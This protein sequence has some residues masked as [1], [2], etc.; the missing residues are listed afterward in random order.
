[1]KSKSFLCTA[2]VAGALTV[3]LAACSTTAAPPEA[4]TA[5]PIT[6]GMVTPLTGIYSALGD[7]ALAAVES[8]V[9]RINAEGGI[10]GHQVNLVYRDDKSEADQSIIAYNELASDPTVV[11][12]LSSSSV[13]NSAATGPA[14]ERAEVPTI[15]LG[16]VQQFTDGSN[17]Y[18]FTA[19]AATGLYAQ[20]I[21]NYVMATGLDSIAVVYALTPY[22][23][24][25]R[26]AT[27]G[28][29]QGA[30]VDIVFEQ[31]FDDQATDFTAVVTGVQASGADGIIVWGTGPAPVILTKQFAAAQVDAQ[32]IFTG[33]QGSSLFLQPAGDA[34]EGVIV[35]TSIAVAGQELPESTLKTAIDV[36]AVPFEEANGEYPPQFAFDGA[37]G[38]QL[39]K[40]A[41]EKA[42]S[43]DRA[44]IRDALETLDVL[45]S[46][47]HYRYAADNHMGLSP[48]ALTV[49]TVDGGAFVATEYAKETFAAKVED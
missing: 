12:I 33:A 49:L 34:A 9:E 27:L 18:A 44:E 28:I 17:P 26:A 11:A 16:P 42:G 38:I 46:N 8:E 14:I 32:L 2:L 20:E 30:G 1:M 40:A 25:G 19:P 45:T 10:D 7:G 4:E 47:G 36:F 31:G 21:I 3:A 37:A 39:I 35:A 48:N 23:E 15:S 22:G 29:A 24:G 41:I 6:I 13:T 43:I 5:E